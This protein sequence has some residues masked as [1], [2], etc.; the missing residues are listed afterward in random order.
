M[1]R[2]AFGR[3]IRQL[4]ERKG[5]AQEGLAH[6]IGVA[7]KQVYRWEKGE[8][9]PELESFAKLMQELGLSELQKALDVLM[10][11]PVDEAPIEADRQE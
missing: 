6:R 5:L 8:T 11:S 9:L 7:T 4:R 2:R 1:S 10:E 3:F